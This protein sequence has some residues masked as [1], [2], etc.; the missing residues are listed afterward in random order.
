MSEVTPPKAGKPKSGWLNVA[1]DYGPVVVF[2]LAYRH[3]S[4]ADSHNAVGAVLAAIKSTAAFMLA[5]V[6]ALGVSKW[7]LGRISPMLWLST[8]LIL[9][10]GALTV[11]LR[12]P[13]WIQRKPTAIYLMF[14]S[15]LLIGAL[16]GKAL[17][18]VLL[19]AAFEG[20][21]D[22]GWMKLS[23]NWG[24][25]FLALAVLNEVLRHFYNAANGN[26]GT[27]IALK[28][29]LF[30]PLSFLFTFMQ[31]PMLLRHGMADEDVAKP[32]D[33]LPPE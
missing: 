6:I 31:V 4:P 20:L 1:V 29:W 15:V 5:A 14:G 21:N 9:G 13:I 30:M 24:W 26:F 32:V 23:R 12:D 27:W 19:E 18:K 8:G 3:Y 7:K 11:L 17:L 33:N 22:E 10:F 28:L 25:F 2:F 16:R